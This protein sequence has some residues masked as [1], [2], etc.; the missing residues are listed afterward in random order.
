MKTWLVVLVVCT[1]G[2]AGCSGDDDSSGSGTDAGTDGGGPGGDGGT[3]AT[4]VDAA[5]DAGPCG[6][7]AAPT[8]VCREAD[9]T[10]V[11]CVADGD[12]S[13]DTPR[14]DTATNECVACLDHEDC[15]DPAAAQCED[16]ACVPCSTS[17]HCAGTGGAVCD[18]SGET[19]TC[20]E[21]TD[22]DSSACGS[23]QTCNLLDGTCVD[24]APGSRGSCES[25]TND[26]QCAT[27]HRCIR[28]EFPTGT[29]RETGHCLRQESAGCSNPYRY[30]ITRTSLSGAAAEPYCGIDEERSTCEAIAAL[31]ADAD[32]TED[33]ACTIDG[34]DTEVPGAVCGRVSGA[35]G[36]CTYECTTSLYCPAAVPCGGT[37]GYCGGS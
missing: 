3:D 11:A 13:G 31:Y 15:T 30:L 18:D 29:P 22:G 7:C 36:K 4:V 12:C 28:L 5:E 20:V 27:D 9:G 21:C 17:D 37:S 6:S 8:P 35:D 24:V 23:S 34:T 2:F 14:C 33:G 32:C 10:C 19:A 26:L 25:C 1:V 16:G